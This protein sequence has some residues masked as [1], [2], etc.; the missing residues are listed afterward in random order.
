[1]DGNYV[2]AWKRNLEVT[3]QLLFNVDGKTVVLPGLVQGEPSGA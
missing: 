3:E 1:M 2:L